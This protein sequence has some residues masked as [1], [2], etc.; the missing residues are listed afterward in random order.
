VIRD[1]PP[2]ALVERDSIISDIHASFRDVIRCDA[3]ISWNECVAR[4]N[5]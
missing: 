2:D 4:D 3:A 5:Y 1:L